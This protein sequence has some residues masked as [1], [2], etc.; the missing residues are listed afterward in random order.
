MR[1]LLLVLP[2]LLS[3]DAVGASAQVRRNRPSQR[4]P[5]RPAQPPAKPVAAP[6][7]ASITTPSGLTYLITRRGE[8][9]APQAGEE[10]LVHYTGLLTDGTVFD[11]SRNRGEPFAFRL[12][13]GRVI[14][15]WDEGIARL[16][17]GDRAT[18]FIPPQL[19]YGA[20]GAGGVI[21][22]D[23]SLIFVVE[24]VGIRGEAPQP[25]E[26]RPPGQ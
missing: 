19:G 25:G 16:R 4:R 9:R 15:G 2:L 22:P 11:S 14:K 23:A 24:L 6:S 1:L 12:G 17:V 3:L 21:P 10:V 5:A 20:R 13:A 7:A 18:L 8:G 26:G